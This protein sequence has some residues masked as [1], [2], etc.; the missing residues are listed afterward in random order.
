MWGVFAGIGIWCALYPWI[1][2][3]LER[4]AA[5]KALAEMRSRSKRGHQWDTLRGRW[6]E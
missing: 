3:W 4:R 5:Q 1:T 2:E 6:M